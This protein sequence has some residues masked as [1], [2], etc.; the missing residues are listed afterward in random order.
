M[1]ARLHFNLPLQEKRQFFA[2][3]LLVLLAPACLEPAAAAE[4]KQIV[5]KVEF[6]Q[7]ESKTCQATL[8]IGF[9]QRNTIAAVNGTIENTMCAASGG[10]YELVISVRDGTGE[11]KT[12]EFTEKWQRSD[13]KTINFSS[14]YPIGDNTDLI[15][16]KV[17]KV[18][19]ACA[20]AAAK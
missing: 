12:L 17:R 13:D 6:V 9:D 20:E 8:G 14:N 4:E 3:T 2:A 1:F 10:D 16:V 7:P 5:T 18:H 19:C 11:V 15:R